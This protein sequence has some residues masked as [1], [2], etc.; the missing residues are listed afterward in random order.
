MW[1]FDPPTSPNAAKHCFNRLF[2]LI[3]PTNQFKKHPC[4]TWCLPPILPFLPPKSK[5]TTPQNT[6][7]KK[8]STTKNEM[9]LRFP[10]SSRFP[11]GDRW[12]ARGTA[13]LRGRAGGPWQGAPGQSS[14]SLVLQRSMNPN[15]PSCNF[16]TMLCQWT[17]KLQVLFSR[18]MVSTTLPDPRF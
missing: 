5:K 8:Q 18:R 12:A 14:W 16:R 2:P 3:F 13:G 4:F 10:S 17:I 15:D 9:F 1:L 11:P 6:K 7:K